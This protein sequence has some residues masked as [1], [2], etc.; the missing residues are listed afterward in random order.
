METSHIAGS[1]ASLAAL[2]LIFV[3]REGIKEGL[4][5]VFSDLSAQQVRSIF[6]ILI[7]ACFAAAYFAGFKISSLIADESE[8]APEV[9]SEQIDE[10]QNDT[11]Q[12]AVDILK[13]TIDK[14]EEYI[15][16]KRTRDSIAL[17]NREKRWVY[18]IG[19]SK[20][21]E[22][23][24]WDAAMAVSP[25]GDIYIFKEERKTYAIICD[26]I[27]GKEELES[28]LEIYAAKL[29]SIGLSYRITIVDLM[30]Y[31]SKKENIIES[32][33][34]DKRK[35]DETFRCLTCDK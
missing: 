1:V 6:I 16:N 18:K 25:L 5:K 30:T 11:I 20:S 21:S 26:P 19:D 23:D 8:T 27:L 35:H 4:K 2:V 33:A 10:Y 31:C 24:A 15:D 13:T 9:T 29:D 14:T 22:S 3:F 34:I 17:A 7:I 12:A 28:S 32:E